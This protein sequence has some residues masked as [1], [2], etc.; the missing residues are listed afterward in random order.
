MKELIAAGADVNLCLDN[1]KYATPLEGAIVNGSLGDVLLLIRAGA[2][3]ERKHL[4]NICSRLEIGIAFSGFA[5]AES[6]GAESD[7]AESEHGS[8]NQD[9]G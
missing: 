1:Y 5:D 2:N 8:L 4:D 7:G 6:D 9:S 3:F